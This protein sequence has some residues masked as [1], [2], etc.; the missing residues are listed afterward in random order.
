MFRGR[1]ERALRERGR[2]AVGEVRAARRARG[3][4]NVLIAVTP[5]DGEMFETHL[6]LDSIDGP[7]PSAGDHVDVLHDGHHAVP[8]DEPVR[9]S[10]PP[11]PPP[12]PDEPGPPPAA[13]DVIGEVLRRL[14]D[15]SLLQGGP[16]IVIGDAPAP[17]PAGTDA[18]GIAE[19]LARA[20]DDPAA[21]G[22]ELLRRVI[23]G[24]ATFAEVRD[25]VRAAGPEGAASAHA[26]LASLRERGLL[27]ARQ[28]ALLAG[29]LR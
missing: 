24:E 21:V 20:S 17:A 27:G 14:A 7:E 28:H 5:D 29:M 13:H 26:V 10:A 6:R 2:P 1:R 4:W 22:D 23:A 9:F 11:P 12:P 18:I 19:L 8:M 16:Q 3:S 25:A 15:G